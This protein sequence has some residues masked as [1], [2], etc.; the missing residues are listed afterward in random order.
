[1]KDV[2]VKIIPGSIFEDERGKVVAVNDFNMLPIKRFYTIQHIDAKVVRAWQGHII[3]QKWF[4]VLSGSFKMLIVK[5]D[6]WKTPSP[7]L[8][9]TEYLLSADKNEVL[10]VPGGFVTGFKAL[11]PHSRIAVYS[12]MTLSESKLD[13]YRFDKGMWHCWD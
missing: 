3:E 7:N 5:P 11:T 10:H 8:P 13:D 12:D 1:M 2:Q 6:N 9:V 4:F